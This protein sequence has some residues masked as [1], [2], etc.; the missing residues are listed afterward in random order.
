MKQWDLNCGSWDFITGSL[1]CSWV[2]SGWTLL[3]MQPRVVVDNLCQQGCTLFGKQP[4]SCLYWHQPCLWEDAIDLRVYQST[5]VNLLCLLKKDFIQF[6]KYVKKREKLQHL[7]SLPSG[8][9]PQD[10]SL[11]YHDNLLCSTLHACSQT[12][13]FIPHQWSAASGHL[14]ASPAEWVYRYSSNTTIHTYA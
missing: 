6:T 3:S 9:P 2:S 14:G 10:V 12:E 5:H 7:L 8:S 11:M 13:G 4:P 1:C